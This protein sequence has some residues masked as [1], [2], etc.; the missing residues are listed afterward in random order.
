MSRVNAFLIARC[1]Q[2]PHPN[3]RR[4]SMCPATTSNPGRCRGEKSPARICRPGAR[5]GLLRCSDVLAGNEEEVAVLIDPA[6]VA[7]RKPFVDNACRWK[8][9]Q[10]AT[11][12]G[13]ASNNV[14]DGA[15]Q[16]E[17]SR[18]HRNAYL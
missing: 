15:D 7:R 3:R 2:T 5:R 1:Y 11:L 12:S 8:Q 10:R 18:C 16:A 13:V 17:T 4:L 9:R 6:E 14:Y